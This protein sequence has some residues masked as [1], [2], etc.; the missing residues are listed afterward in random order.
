MSEEKVRQD[1]K[2]FFEV[3]F[4]SRDRRAIVVGLGILFLGAISIEGCSGVIGVALCG[5]GIFW[6]IFV[7]IVSRPKAGVDQWSA[8]EEYFSLFRFDKAK[9]AFDN[10]TSISVIR[11]YR[12]VAFDRI[13]QQSLEKM[14]LDE[15]Q[16]TGE[17]I[18]IAGPLF[19][20]EVSGIDTSLVRRRAVEGSETFIYSTYRVTVFHFTSGFLAAYS[21]DYN[22]T[23]DVALN[24]NTDEYFYKDIV[25]VKT[26]T[27]LTNFTLDVGQ[28]HEHSKLFRLTASSGDKVEVTL[29][30]ERIAAED[31]IVSRG[32]RAVANIRT[33]L[34]D[35]KNTADA[36]NSSSSQ[37]S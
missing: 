2:D 12:Q 14:G 30:S 17:S 37:S 7:P 6:M 19:P 35:Y 32:E 25:S 26:V 36:S 10:I 21:A 3:P 4:A 33:M 20:Q 34:R 13:M 24:E 9:K 29:S 11:E 27:E 15:S 22:L 16:A 28:V 18:I 8:P 1:V 23:K 5:V 31:E